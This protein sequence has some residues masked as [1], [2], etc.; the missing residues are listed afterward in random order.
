MRDAPALHGR[1]QLDDAVAALL[2]ELGEQV[3]GVVGLHAREHR[4]DL[5][6]G[7]VLEQLAGA[8]VLELLEQVG[9]ELGIVVHGGEDLLAFGGAPPPRRGRRS[10]RDAGARAS[11]CGTFRRTVGTW[12]VNGSTLAQSSRRMPSPASRSA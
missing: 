6:V 11:G 12:P 7:P 2:V 9:L 5:L 10:A 1:Q 4:G 8:R 3:D